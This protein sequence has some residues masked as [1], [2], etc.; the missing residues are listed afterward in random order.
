MKKIIAFLG[1]LLAITCIFGK[2][3]KNHGITEI[4]IQRGACYG[5]CPIYTFTVKS[6]G[7]FRYKG[8]KYVERIGDF[9]GT[10]D[11]AAFNRLAQFIMDSGYV[12]LAD[13]YTTP[14]TDGPTVHSHVVANGKTKTISDYANSGPK[15][16][17]AVEQQ[18]DNLL[19]SAKWDRTNSPVVESSKELGFDFRR[20]V[21]AEPVSNSFE[22]VGHFLFLY[23]GDKRLSQVDSCSVSPSGRYVIYQNAPSGYLFLFRRSDSR[24]TQLTSHFVALVDTFEW[25]ERTRTVA[26]RFTSGHVETFPLP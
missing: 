2:P 23:Y 1:C 22:S 26:A 3:A 24:L 10:V 21:I 8:I 17:E 13:N 15:S 14:I 5:R 18:I 4:G 16:L 7:T 12:D 11:V 19:V 9:T 25:Q 20:V 6:D